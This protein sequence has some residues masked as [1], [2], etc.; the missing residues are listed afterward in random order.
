VDHQATLAAQLVELRAAVA[1]DGGVTVG[2]EQLEILCPGYLSVSE[3]F[4]R[5]AYIAQKEGWSFAFLTDGSVR[6]GAYAN[7]G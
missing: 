7:S 4:A 2:C 6:F 1:A 5:V 3:Q